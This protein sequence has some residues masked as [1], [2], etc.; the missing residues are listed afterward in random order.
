MQK[1][2]ALITAFI[3]LIIG[4]GGVFLLDKILKS[5][6]SGKWLF[7]LSLVV[8]LFIL[9]AI[10]ILFL[11]KIYYKFHFIRKWLYPDTYIEGVWIQ[12]ID[13]DNLEQMPPTK[14]SIVNIKKK[15]GRIV[16]DGHSY[17]QEKEGKKIT[18]FRIPY[19]EFKEESKELEY[20]Y[21]FGTSESKEKH[22]GIGRASLVFDKTTG[23]KYFNKYNG[24]ITCDLPREKNGILVSAFRNPKKIRLENKEEVEINEQT[25]KRQDVRNYI[26]KY[27]K[28]I[29]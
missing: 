1:F 17:N 18:S 22:S 3:D 14:Y 28:E 10:N 29:N 5:E 23:E 12:I 21:F 19:A 11:C 4:T 16:V 7:V 15:E 27:I 13:D 25:I 24:T 2:W 9:Y 6:T 26:D 8:C 20:L